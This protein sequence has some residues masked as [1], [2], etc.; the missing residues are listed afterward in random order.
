MTQTIVN[1]FVNNDCKTNVSEIIHNIISWLNANDGFT[2]ALLALITALAAIFIP[3][4]TAKKQNKIA[5]FQVNLKCY[6]SLN[7]IMIF[8][9]FVSEF[10]TFEENLDSEA[11]VHSPVEACRKKYLEIHDPLSDKKAISQIRFSDIWKTTFIRNCISLDYKAICSGAFLTKAITLN[12]AEKITKTLD[13]F[14]IALF[15]SKDPTIITEKCEAFVK[16]KVE[17][18]KLIDALSK[19]LKV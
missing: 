3:V 1:F 15:D 19:R 18:H 16:N 2:S 5:L 10:A 13:E 12:D 11:K 17:I 14:V 9:A 6:R 7:S 8:F 4:C